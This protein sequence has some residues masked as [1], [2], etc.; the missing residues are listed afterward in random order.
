MNA[1]CPMKFEKNDVTNLSRIF[2]AGSQQGTFNIQDYVTIGTV[3]ARLDKA[4]NALN[5]AASSSSAC[6]GCPFQF[7][8]QDVLVFRRVIEI[9]TRKG[10]FG[11]NELINVGVLY[12]KLVEATTTKSEKPELSALEKIEN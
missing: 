6:G 7:T 8:E 3:Y 9:C 10:L 11:A 12:N 2:Q 1:M 5:S 4:V